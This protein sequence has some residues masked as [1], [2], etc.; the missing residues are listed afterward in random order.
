MAEDFQFSEEDLLLLSES[1]KQL[2]KIKFSRQELTAIAYLAYKSGLGMD[3]LDKP[4]KERISTY[5]EFAKKFVAL[6]PEE[7]RKLI[8]ESGKPHSMPKKEK[9]KKI[10]LAGNKMPRIVA[11]VTKPL[12]DERKNEFIQSLFFNEKEYNGVIGVLNAKKTVLEYKDINEC[13]HEVMLWPELNCI[14]AIKTDSEKPETI[15]APDQSEK[16]NF[17]FRSTIVIGD[18]DCKGYKQQPKNPED[19]KATL[20]VLPLAV[21]GKFICSNWNHDLFYEIEQF[22]YAKSIDCSY[23]IGDLYDLYDM[24]QRL[25]TINGK[26]LTTQIVIQNDLIS[27]NYLKKVLKKGPQEEEC[28]ALNDIVQFLKDHPDIQII[29]TGDKNLMLAID[30]AKGAIAEQNEKKQENEPTQDVGP[31]TTTAQ[32]AP[33]FINLDKIMSDLRVEQPDV[34][35]SVLSDDDIQNVAHGMK[36]KFV[37]TDNNGHVIEIRSDATAGF[38]TQIINAAK[39]KIKEPNTANSEQK[40][41][42]PGKTTHSNTQHKPKKRILWITQSV[43]DTLQEYHGQ[44]F[45]DRIKWLQSL[46]NPIRKFKIQNVEGIKNGK[47]YELTPEKIFKGGMR[48]YVASVEPEQMLAFCLGSK[49]TQNSTDM[50]NVKASASLFTT[51]NDELKKIDSTVPQ[52]IIHGET[53]Y[54]FNTAETRK[55]LGIDASDKEK[56]ATNSITRDMAKQAESVGQQTPP[57]QQAFIPDTSKKSEWQSLEKAAELYCEKHPD[58]NEQE[59]IDKLYDACKNLEDKKHRPSDMF[60]K[61][62]DTYFIYEDNRDEFIEMV[63]SGTTNEDVPVANDQEIPP[64][65]RTKMKSLVEWAEQFSYDGLPYM[66]PN[67]SDGSDSV[68][69]RGIR[70]EL[71]DLIINTLLYTKHGKDGRTVA[72]IVGHE[73]YYIEKNAIEYHTIADVRTFKAFVR[74]WIEKLVPVDF[75]VRTKDIRPQ[76]LVRICNQL[77]REN[78]LAENNKYFYRTDPRFMFVSKYY[79]VKANLDEFIQTYFPGKTNTQEKQPMNKNKNT[80]QTKQ[81]R[82]E[83]KT[84][85]SARFIVSQL[86]D[87]YDCNIHEDLFVLLVNKYN[88]NFQD[89]LEYRDGDLYE[90]KQQLEE[91]ANYIKNNIPHLIGKWKTSEQAAKLYYNDKY[92]TPRGINVYDLTNVLAN[93]CRTMGVNDETKTYF[94]KYGDTY[95][96]NITN[97]PTFIKMYLP[98]FVRTPKEF[99]SGDNQATSEAPQQT[100][101]T[102]WLTIEQLAEQLQTTPDVIRQVN[103]QYKVSH[104]HPDW[105]S[106]RRD[107]RFNPEKVGD[108]RNEYGDIIRELTQLQPGNDVDVQ[109]E[110]IVIIPPKQTPVSEPEPEQKQPAPQFNGMLGVKAFMAKLD[111]IM[112]LINKNLQEKEETEREIQSL[113]AEIQE[114]NQQAINKINTNDIDSATQLLT[115]TKQKQ[116]A[117]EDAT[118]KAEQL[119]IERKKLR[120]R[121]DE[122]SQKLRQYN[123]AQNKQKAAEQAVQIANEEA[124]KAND[125]LQQF[126]ESGFNLD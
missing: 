83:H 8:I 93:T 41:I 23:S 59:I 68:R 9:T 77:V 55:L 63:L 40:D 92:K 58:A 44:P 71:M 51:I 61:I 5:M 113:N 67:E 85:K 14:F 118:K 50:D 18:F 16:G 81:P 90:I 99:T 104:N 62:D 66:G 122:A 70:S 115:K 2:A 42:I 111:A 107:W 125:D 31:T 80:D 28:A 17:D 4:E 22:P 34:D 98:D 38:H 69:K 102:E 109:Q 39:T 26:I 6:S 11:I 52:T 21:Y 65:K 45:K 37:K 91:L 57:F 33:S 101:E 97:L 95:F 72:E 78:K 46:S 13:G 7:K 82:T 119:D 88:A 47:A 121:F 24:I 48:L 53:L 110:P 10:M 124:R 112:E 120:A 74:A 89:Y 96:W 76:V 3:F 126:L 87:K 12:S 29:G 1:D 64:E 30:A 103:R 117:L 20:K 19:I 106:G 27:L 105:T 32:W 79:F 100:T 35:F 43:L 114:I 108:Y 60:R 15:V 36:P 94:A 56:S 116:Q 54:N 25:P 73:R 86:R 123:E 84:V 49:K 75:V